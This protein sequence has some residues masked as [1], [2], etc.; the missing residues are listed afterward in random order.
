MSPRRRAIQARD[1]VYLH[2]LRVDAVI[3]VHEWEQQVRQTLSIDLE[4][5][6]DTQ[7]AAASDRLQDALDYAAVARRLG[8]LAQAN[9]RQLLEG[10]AE[11][12]ADTLQRE[13][14]VPW[15]RLRLSKPG[16][17]PACA[18]VG[19]LIERGERQ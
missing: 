11:T 8:E 14:A 13:F 2:G 4:M 9:R 10:L 3:G 18:D 6:C 7:I 15:L 19:V 5:A 17:V 1:I 16:A 12:M